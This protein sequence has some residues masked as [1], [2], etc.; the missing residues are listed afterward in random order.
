VSIN[1]R[2]A[3]FPNLEK[4]ISMKYALCSI[5][6]MDPLDSEPYPFSRANCRMML[7]DDS[8]ALKEKSSASSLLA[9]QCVRPVKFLAS[10]YRLWESSH[11]CFDLTKGNVVEMDLKMNS[12][13]A[14]FVEMGFQQNAVNYVF[15][16]FGFALGWSDILP[17]LS[18]DAT[19]SSHITN[20]I[21]DVK[22]SLILCEKRVDYNNGDYKDGIWDGDIF[23]EGI[24]RVTD[25]GPGISLY[26]GD[27]KN[28]KMN[29]RGKIT[30]SNGAIYDGDLV[31][32]KYEGYG[33]MCW[34]DGDVYEGEWKADKKYGQG[35]LTT[36]DYVGTYI[37]VDRDFQ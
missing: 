34:A 13:I 17:I 36:Q 28:G 7:S 20:E 31:D 1:L 26:E 8:E 10:R 11:K 29:G 37:P 12:F 14:D 32:D 6:L 27:W 16:S 25:S 2:F 35:T 30:F 33:K 4:I 15:N 22:D 23:L 3:D 18:D 9:W 19:T 21:R 24:V 5:V